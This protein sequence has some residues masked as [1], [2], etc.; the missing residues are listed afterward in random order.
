MNISVLYVKEKQMEQ[1]LHI[2]TNCVNIKKN[3]YVGGSE[4][5]YAGTD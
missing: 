5:G 3:P 1:M 4:A 2:L